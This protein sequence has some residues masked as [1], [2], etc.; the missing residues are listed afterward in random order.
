MLNVV[1]FKIWLFWRNSQFAYGTVTASEQGL[2][3]FNEPIDWNFDNLLKRDM[4]IL[5][6]KEVMWKHK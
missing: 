2:I 3:F 5:V 4:E 6:L 1:N